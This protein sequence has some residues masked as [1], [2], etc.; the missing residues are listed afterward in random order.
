MTLDW[1]EDVA[2]GQSNEVERTF[3]F[4]IISQKTERQV[5]LAER[6]TNYHILLTC[7]LIKEY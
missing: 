4:H 3:N 7:L 6:K 5:T 1:K 2:T